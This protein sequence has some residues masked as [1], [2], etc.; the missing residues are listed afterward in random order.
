MMECKSY[1]KNK[2]IPENK[3]IFVHGFK[4]IKTNEI[5]NYVLTGC[6]SDEIF[7]NDKLFNFWSK[8]FINKGIEM[9]NFKLTGW[10]FMTLVKSN[11][12]FKIQSFVCS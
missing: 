11:N 8:K 3:E 9:R 10:P 6:D 5:D 7:E 4:H 1:M 12:F 2:D